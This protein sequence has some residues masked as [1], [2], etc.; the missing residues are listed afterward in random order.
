M[1]SKLD[2]KLKIEKFLK[3]ELWQHLIVVAF[4]FVVG[5]FSEKVIEA[6]FFIVSHFVIRKEFSK[7]YHCKNTTSCLIT[8]FFV[9]L[10]GVYI[11][12]PIYVSIL[13]VIPSCFFI[14]WIGYILQDRIDLIQE[15]KQK[16]LYSMTETELRKYGAENGLSELQ[17][18]IL[19]H[20]VIEHLKISEI[21]EYRNYSRT[22]IKYHICQIKK[23]LNIEKV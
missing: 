6:V 18:D 12:F 13:S 20:R 1:K 10:F 16:K 23:K 8:T 11:S 14:C 21:C 17:Q 5:F 7:Q 3:D 9:I 2:E 4:V 15:K 22:N 19:V